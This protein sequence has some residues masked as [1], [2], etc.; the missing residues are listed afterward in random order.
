M[1]KRLV[2]AAAALLI[3]GASAGPA[4]AQFNPTRQI[5]L[6]VHSGPGAG[7]DVF[8]RLLISTLE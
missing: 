8:G 6:V 1:D 5:E 3:A 2:V 4:A 7:N